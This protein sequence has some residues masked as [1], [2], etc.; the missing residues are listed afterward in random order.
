MSLTID[1]GYIE[2]SLTKT[3]ASDENGD[4]V[5]MEGRTDDSRCCQRESPWQHDDQDYPLTSPYHF[6]FLITST[7]VN[8][9]LILE[10]EYVPVR[11]HCTST[12][13]HF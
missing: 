13:M 5:T 11:L 10:I 6:T 4:L 7:A 8:T 12:Y 3:S 9:T 1:S 2:F